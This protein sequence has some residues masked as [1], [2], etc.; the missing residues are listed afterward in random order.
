MKLKNLIVITLTIILMTS[1]SDNVISDSINNSVSIGESNSSSIGNVLSTSNSVG[2]DSNDDF[3]NLTKDEAI[4]IIENAVLNMKEKTGLSMNE[5]LNLSFNSEFLTEYKY[6]LKTEKERSQIKLDLKS[7]TSIGLVNK[8]S[9]IE[10]MLEGTF[11]LDATT[12][13]I[14]RSDEETKN[15]YTLIGNGSL[16]VKDEDAYL[17]IDANLTTNG[18]DN[19]IDKV[20]NE[21]LKVLVEELID[22]LKKTIEEYSPDFSIDDPDKIRLML[23]DI[24]DVLPG[25]K[26]YQEDNNMLLIYKITDENMQDIIPIVVEY[27]FED[28][29]G[30]IFSGS[31]EDMIKKS[32]K[33]NKLEATILIENN[34]FIKDTSIEIDVNVD[35]LL[36]NVEAFITPSIGTK[37]EYISIDLLMSEHAT[38]EILPTDYVINFPEEMLNE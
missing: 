26:A 8:E 13:K 14:D 7:D 16:F 6:V 1:C 36:T 15:E 9:G 11:D 4:A 35:N 31:I 3:I 12:K 37:Y 23:Q 21:P 17:K 25:P 38:Y 19:K 29:T 33:I 18:E 28:K 27:M 5:S 34:D 22:L 30:G 32:I 2:N 24:E 10:S 20:K